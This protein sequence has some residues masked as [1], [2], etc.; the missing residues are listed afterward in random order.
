MTRHQHGLS[1]LAQRCTY[2]SAAGL[3]LAGRR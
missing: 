3:F 1:L 2:I